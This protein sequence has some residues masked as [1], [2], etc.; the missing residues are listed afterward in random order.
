MVLNSCTVPGYN[1]FHKDQKSNIQSRPFAGGGVI[2]YACDGLERNPRHDLKSDKL[3][4]ICHELRQ[5]R[6]A[7][8]CLSCLYRPPNTSPAFLEDLT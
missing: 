8:F 5:H 2:I 7:S 6:C 4:E 1:L 3:E